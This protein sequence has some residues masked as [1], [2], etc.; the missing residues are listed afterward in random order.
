MSTVEEHVLQFP[1]SIRLDAPLEKAPEQTHKIAFRPYGDWKNAKK[2][3]VTAH[4]LT[5]DTLNFHYLSQFCIQKKKD[6]AVINID[7]MGRGDSHPDDQNEKVDDEHFT[8]SQYCND[9]IFILNQVKNEN[10]N[11]T[12]LKWFWVGTSMGGLLNMI[13]TDKEKE[14]EKLKIHFSALM[15]NDVGPLIP[16]SEINRISQYVTIDTRFKTRQEALEYFE[17]IYKAHFGPKADSIFYAHRAL[18]GLKFDEESIKDE[19]ILP[20]KVGYD[21]Q[22]VKHGLLDTTVG[23]ILDL[24]REVLKEEVGVDQNGV[25]GMC[26]SFLEQFKKLKA[27][28]LLYHGKE[29]VLLPQKVVDLMEN[30]YKNDIKLDFKCIS[31]DNTGHVPPLYIEEEFLPIFEWF[32]KY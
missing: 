18:Y 9:I 11:N 15:Y 32:E 4:G 27:P 19:N 29:S 13:L 31:W 28:L 23:G 3:I 20:Y 25:I 14:L 16:S 10:N 30:V 12:N 5:G 6:Y 26:V 22:G 24:E 1:P 17:K 21:R 2:L 7:I 8:Y